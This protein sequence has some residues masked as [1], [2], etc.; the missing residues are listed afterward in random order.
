MTQLIGYV[1]HVS[2]LTLGDCE[3][4]SI[5]WIKFVSCFVKLFIVWEKYC[6]DN[7]R[8][9]FSFTL[10]SGLSYATEWRHIITCLSPYLNK[11]ARVLMRKQNNNVLFIKFFS[12]KE[13]FCKSSSWSM[14]KTNECVLFYCFSDV[15]YSR[16][17]FLQYVDTLYIKRIDYSRC[18]WRK[19]L[20]ESAAHYNSLSF[21]T[22]KT[23]INITKQNST[24]KK[25]RNNKPLKGIW[26]RH[27]Q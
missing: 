20:K 13:K 5:V 24:L 15:L 3:Y 2:R 16:F 7:E 23:F 25:K 8:Q 11:L 4:L 10:S 18:D 14:K 26:K 6:V 17:F 9:T 19:Q 22:D 1:L 12:E 21:F 27:I